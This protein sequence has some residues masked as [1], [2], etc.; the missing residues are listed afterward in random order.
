MGFRSR[1]ALS[2]HWLLLAILFAGAEARAN[3]TQVDAAYEAAQVQKIGS[4]ES[5]RN[6]TVNAMKGL[7]DLSEQRRASAIQHGHKA[8]GQFRNSED[9]DVMRLKNHVTFYKLQSGNFKV[10]SSGSS[11]ALRILEPVSDTMTDYKRLDPKFLR[12][13]EAGKVADE[14]EK[15]SGMKREAFL[16]V[17]SRASRGTISASDPDMVDKVISQFEKFVKEIPNENFRR[18]VEKTINEV[19]ESARRGLLAKGVQK[20][21]EIMAAMPKEK[22]APA[23]ATSPGKPA[24]QPAALVAEAA[25]AAEPAQTPEAAP[26]VSNVAMVPNESG[27]KGLDKEEFS[28]DPLGSVMQTAIDAQKEDTIFKQVSKRY[29]ALAPKLSMVSLHSP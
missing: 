5:L 12:E 14:F 2:K 17:M 29:R 18:G 28:G 10:D 25:P 20:I 27:Y 9:M 6:S 15:K 1:I 7:M 11:S 8:Y 24:R 3:L 23:P 26:G 13:G 4:D 21:A 16:Q 19:P 22:G